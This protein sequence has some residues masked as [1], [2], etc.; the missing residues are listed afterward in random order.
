MLKTDCA[1]LENELMDV[2]RMFRLRPENTEHSFRYQDGVFYNQF[3]V[4]GERFSFED[5]GQVSD[6]IQLKRL[7]RRFA[8]LGLYRILSEKYKTKM[9][10]GALTGIRPTK[11]AYGEL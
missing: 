7:E 11:L 1:F 4:D 5:R 2:E 3:T 6:E 9:P 10:W 8:K